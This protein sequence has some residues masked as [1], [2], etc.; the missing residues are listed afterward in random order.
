MDYRY[1]LNLQYH[2]IPTD[3]GQYDND[4]RYSEQ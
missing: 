4:F 2:L 3:A 1:N